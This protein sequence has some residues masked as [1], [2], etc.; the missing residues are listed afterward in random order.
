MNDVPVPT[1]TLG[2]L[3]T[4]EFPADNNSIIDEG[5]LKDNS[6]LGLAGP[7]KSGKSLIL[8]TIIANVVTGQPLFG[9][10]RTNHGRAVI[11]AFQVLRPQRVL[12]LEQEIG[13]QDLRDRLRPLY[14]SHSSEQRKLLS[15]NLLCHSLDYRLQLDTSPHNLSALVQQYR[16]GILAL[17]PFI[18]FHTS[19]ENDTQSMRKILHHLDQIRQSYNL[20]VIITHH[21]GKEG[22]TP[23]QGLDLFRGSSVFAGKIDSAILIHNHGLNTGQSRLDFVIRRGKPIKPVFVGVD[24]NDLVTRFICWASDPKKKEKLVKLDIE[25]MD[26]VM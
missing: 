2:N 13:S 5:I 11:P 23:K 18:E 12:L 15:D 19:N 9:A 17:D 26:V 10:Y 20:A 21:T 25:N 4:H 6:I 14:E 1:F 22:M 3:L 8:N 16:P 24:E 7:A